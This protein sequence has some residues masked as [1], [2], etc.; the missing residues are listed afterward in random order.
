MAEVATH[1]FEA[2]VADVRAGTFPDGEHSYAM[3]P[4]EAEKLAVALK[5]GGS[6]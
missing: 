5:A 6:E 4:A 3:P 2:F 1:A